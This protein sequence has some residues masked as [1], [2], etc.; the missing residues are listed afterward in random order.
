MWASLQAYVCS[1]VHTAPLFTQSFVYL[2]DR[3]SENHSISVT[4]KR[5]KWFLHSESSEA[6]GADINPI[7]ACLQNYSCCG[8]Y[9]KKCTGWHWPWWEIRKH[10]P[11]GVII[12]LQFKGRIRVGWEKAENIRGWAGSTAV[13]TWLTPAADR[14]P[15]PLDAGSRGRQQPGG[16]QGSDQ[17]GIG[18]GAKYLGLSCFKVD[19]GGDRIRFAF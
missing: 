19:M 9:E 11:E 8:G 18:G 1:F 7:I 10:L 17:E 5:E 14:R 15:A 4:E 12:E 2:L 3:I 16:Q 13:T 6:T